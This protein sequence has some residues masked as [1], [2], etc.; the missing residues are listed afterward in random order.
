M[1]FLRIIFFCTQG[2]LK[3]YW[4]VSDIILYYIY[5]FVKHFSMGTKAGQRENECI[6]DDDTMSE[7]L[8]ADH[9]YKTLVR[10]FLTFI[11][12]HIKLCLCWK[13]RLGCSCYHNVYYKPFRP[14]YP[15]ILCYTESTFLFLYKKLL[16]N[17]NCMFAVCKFSDHLLTNRVA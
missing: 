17:N 1:R 6:D 4:T 10:N 12:S 2:S 15:F 7:S 5:F 9:E 3:P 13:N 14:P 8:L 11:A 16:M